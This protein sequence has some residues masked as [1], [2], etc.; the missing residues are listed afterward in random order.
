[1]L[2]RIIEDDD[3]LDL[4]RGQKNFPK[5]IGVDFKSKIFLLQQNQLREEKRRKEAEEKKKEEKQLTIDALNQGRMPYF[6]PKCI[7]W[8][9]YFT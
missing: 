5:T 2:Q 7:I 9:L 4:F 3:E 1:M 8:L 6:A